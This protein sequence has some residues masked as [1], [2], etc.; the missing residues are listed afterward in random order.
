VRW[1]TESGCVACAPAGNDRTQ[2]RADYRIQLQVDPKHLYRDMP[3]T[4][5]N[6]NSHDANN[7]NLFHWAL[8]RDQVARDIEIARSS[9]VSGS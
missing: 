6:R 1:P 7:N 2:P 8:I 5:Y 3:L 4:H 9:S